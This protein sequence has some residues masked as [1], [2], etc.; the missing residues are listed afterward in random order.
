ML[1]V[2]LAPDAG[3]V[4]ALLINSTSSTRG[5]PFVFSNTDFPN[6]ALGAKSGIV[7][8]RSVL[9][10]SDVAMSTAVRM[11]AS[12]PYVSPVA[13][14]DGPVTDYLADGGY[15]DNS[16]VVSALEFLRES[17]VDQR[18]GQEILLL[19]IDG[20]PKKAPKCR[21]DTMAR[22]WIYQLVAPLETLYNAKTSGQELRGD[23]EWN[24]YQ[25]LPKS[26]K[27][28]SLT[29]RYAPSPYF[30]GTTRVDCNDTPPLSWHL[31]RQE[32]NCI[33]AAWKRPDGDSEFCSVQVGKFLSGATLDK[34]YESRC[35]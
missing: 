3:T 19:R 12:F 29:V 21:S 22:N 13:R 8:F 31:T 24:L 28:V 15:Y 30:E 14:A 34:G 27:V 10:N 4:P 11:S 35:N 23:S 20:F 6:G 16:G 2:A 7:G 32:K 9:P 26:A 5:V 17:K 1:G 25:E 33:G 18:N